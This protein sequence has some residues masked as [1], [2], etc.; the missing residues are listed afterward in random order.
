MSG[1]H[2]GSS[3]RAD[4][5]TGGQPSYDQFSRIMGWNSSDGPSQDWGDNGFGGAFSPMG[6]AG[7]S[8]KGQ[9]NTINDQREAMYHYMFGQG[10]FG[11]QTPREPTPYQPAR[12]HVSPWGMG[13]YGGGGNMF[14]GGGYSPYGI[15][16]PYR[17]FY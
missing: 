11:Q 1:G 2:G 6:R 14:Y 7:M 4:P 17:R 5:Y 13:G 12:Q 9:G 16:S 8:A 10:G 3:R 15:Y